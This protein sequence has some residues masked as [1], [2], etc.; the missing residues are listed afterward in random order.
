[1]QMGRSSITITELTMSWASCHPFGNLALPSP[2]RLLI[3]ETSAWLALNLYYA[4]SPDS[5]D[6]SFTALA[7]K[8]AH[9]HQN[10]DNLGIE[11]VSAIRKRSRLRNNGVR[12]PHPSIDTHTHLASPV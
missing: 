9:F 1:M 10:S 7:G 4:H 11:D 3:F 6:S 2:R 12:L 8:K 5:P